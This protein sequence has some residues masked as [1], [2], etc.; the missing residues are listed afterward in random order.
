MLF[1]LCSVVIWL[2]FIVQGKTFVWNVDGISQHIPALVFFRHWLGEIANSVFAGKPDIPMWSFSLGE[3]SDVINTLHYYCIGDPL[4][5]LVALFPANFMGIC[6]TILSVIRMYLAGVTFIFLGREIRP[7]ASVTAFVAGGLTYSL[8]NWAL[9]CAARHSFF[10]NPLILLPLMLL[11]IEKIGRGK[12]PYLFII[13]TALAAVTSVYFFY[14]MVIM[15]IIYAVIGFPKIKA[16]LLMLASGIAGCLIGAVMIVPQAIFLT[17]D[18]RSGDKGGAVFFYDVMHYLK[19]PAGFASGG[20]SDYLLMGF[21]AAGV[22]ALIF[23]FAAKGNIKLKIFSGVALLFM[24]L[25]VLGSLMNG[26]SYATNRWSF[27]LTL[28][29]SYLIFAIWDSFVE[30][31]GNFFKKGI[32]IFAVYGALIIGLSFATGDIMLS[33]VQALAGVLFLFASYKTCGN[34][35]WR[36]GRACAI[37]LI[38]NLMINGLIPNTPPGGDRTSEFL[39]N[40][41]VNL[42]MET[43][44]SAAI[45]KISEGNEKYPVRYS[46]PYLNENTSAVFGTFST[47]YYWSQTN[48][49]VT[50]ARRALALP[51][52]RDYYYNGYDGRAVPDYIAGVRYYVVP[53]EFKDSIKA[54]AGYSDPQKSGGF[55]IYETANAAPFAMFFDKTVSEDTWNGLPVSRKQD[56]LMTHAVIRDAENIDVNSDAAILRAEDNIDITSDGSEVMSLDVE[57]PSEGELY[58]VIRG[59]GFKGYNGEDRADL[60]VSGKGVS[61]YTKDFNWYNGKSDFAVCLGVVDQGLRKPKITFTTPG[62]YHFSQ[63]TVEFIP[64]DPMIGKAQDLKVRSSCIKDVRAKGDRVSFNVSS[65]CEGYIVLQI[66]YS[67]GW[68]A[69][70]DGKECGTVPA[71]L[72]YTGIK[73]AAGDHKVTLK[74]RT[75]GIAAGALISVISLVLLIAVFVLDKTVLSR[76]KKN[77]AM[78]SDK[79]LIAVASHKLYDMPQGQI[80]QPVLAGAS[81]SSLDLPEGWK[82]DD[83]GDNISDK[84]PYYCELT[85]Y[86][87]AVCNAGSDVKYIGLVHYRRLFGTKKK[88]AVADEV[89]KSYLPGTKVFVPRPRD[90]Y[91]ETLGSHYSHTLDSSGLDAARQAL[92]TVSPEYVPSWDKILCECSGYMFNMNIMERSLAEDYLTWLMK[93]LEEVCRIKDPA[94]EGSDFDKRFPGRISELLFNCWL[95]HSVSSGKVSPDSIAE[96]DYYSPEKVNWPKKITAF[97][98]AKFL[99]KKYHKSF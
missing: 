36:D 60:S 13:V 42:A 65:P 18:G 8:S 25:P 94:S 71:D 83:T 75:P 97:L 43:S 32:I 89:L 49:A 95:D 50:A 40:D 66:P 47:Q 57:C 77:A 74:Y 5:L 17:G 15:S 70:V 39:T 63:V 92:K 19:I 12:R 41:Q 58:V 33:I 61:Y 72:M 26:M 80:Y 10:L 44:D 81:G 2:P 96:L 21:G 9:Y 79:F 7:K 54:P 82:G 27:A 91:I 55:M 86:Y 48:G 59:M 31:G 20:T 62:Q 37:V 6:Y 64:K 38:V 22:V 73:T 56:I 16:L 24:I 85:P 88:G 11:G 78:S 52:Y 84:N 1:A 28:L 34:L 46:G 87:W 45:A 53:E 67:S 69:V 30:V 4:C 76:R 68:T 93:V 98:K 23:L 99:G 90:Y 29:V 35:K 14:M 51:E 3:G